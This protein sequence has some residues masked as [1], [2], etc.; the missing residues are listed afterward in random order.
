VGSSLAPNYVF[1]IVLNDSNDLEIW[2][3]KNLYCFSGLKVR[4]NVGRRFAEAVEHSIGAEIQ[5]LGGWKYAS[6][7]AW[8]V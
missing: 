3:N 5:P 2:A 8:P 1:L 6:L 7:A 4:S